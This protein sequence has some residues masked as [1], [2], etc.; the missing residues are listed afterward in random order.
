MSILKIVNIIA[1]ENKRKQKDKEEREREFNKS[2][3]LKG[4]FTLGI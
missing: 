1:V 3:Y 4:N 2:K